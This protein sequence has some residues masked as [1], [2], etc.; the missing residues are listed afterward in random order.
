[1]ELDGFAHGE[2]VLLGEEGG[3]EGGFAIVIELLVG[4]AGE[5]G[6]LAHSRV[7]HRDQLNLVDLVALL[8][9]HIEL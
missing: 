7:A 9:R 5:D 2:G 8:L 6:G 4:E 3:A 1:M